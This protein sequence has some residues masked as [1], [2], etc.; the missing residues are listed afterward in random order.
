MAEAIFTEIVKKQGLDSKINKIDSAGTAGYHIGDVPDSR[1]I[2]VCKAHNVP[3][4]HIGRQIC[5]KDFEDFDWI[6]VMDRENLTNVERIK[7]SK[8]KAQIQL[9]GHFDP[10]G[11]I[12]IK[13]PYYGGSSG[14]E[15]NFQQVTRSSFG[16][17]QHLGILGVN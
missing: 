13:D 2:D 5:I 17:L 12:I 8:S 4:D 15:R 14:F 3:I 10:E 9:L 6:L 1:T 11:D 16:F 7:P